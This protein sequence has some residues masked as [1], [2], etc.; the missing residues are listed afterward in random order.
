MQESGITNHQGNTVMKKITLKQ[1]LKWAG[2]ANLLAKRL[3]ITRQAV[4][5]WK[6]IIPEM[7]RFQ[8]MVLIHEE[9]NND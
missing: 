9:K 3:G 5:D 6:G 4:S 8:I 1:A 2:N 7:R